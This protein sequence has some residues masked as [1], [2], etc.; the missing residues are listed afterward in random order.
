MWLWA[1]RLRRGRTRAV[2][3]NG[4][5]PCW[6]DALSFTVARPE[7]AVVRFTVL[8]KGV[9][10]GQAVCPVACMR[11]GLRSVALW[12]TQHEP[13]DAASLLVDVTLTPTDD[14]P[15]P[16][17]AAVSAAAAAAA[18]EAE[19]DGADPDA[20]SAFALAALSALGMCGPVDASPESSPKT[21][22]A[23]TMAVIAEQHSD[24]E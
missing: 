11:Q 9:V 4:F 1:N 13:S 22:R 7:L 5:N 14:A 15:S 21:A 16:G 17:P 20:P 3:D 6:G 10:L 23:A 19:D 8:A 24:D 18:D 12:S 2:P